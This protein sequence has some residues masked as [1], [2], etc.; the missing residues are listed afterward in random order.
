MNADFSL[1][2]H[3]HCII[4]KIGCLLNLIT[5]AQLINK[6]VMLWY[7]YPVFWSLQYSLQF[8]PAWTIYNLSSRKKKKSIVQLTAH[9]E[10]TFLKQRTYLYKKRIFLHVFETILKF[11]DS[12]NATN[13]FVQYILQSCL[14]FQ[15]SL[16]CL[17]FTN[18]LKRYR[19][20]SREH[21]TRQNKYKINS[22]YVA[23]FI[24]VIIIIIS[25]SGLKKK[26]FLIAV[27]GWFSISFVS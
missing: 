6:I 7:M 23:V 11:N 27:L 4:I 25:S 2:R 20:D 5:C 26:T 14:Q 16:K 13:S 15:A 9:V 8:C 1:A 21:P 12:S 17:K 24:H 3:L 19:G 10:V 18:P 22:S